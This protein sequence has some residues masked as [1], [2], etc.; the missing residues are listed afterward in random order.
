V[1]VVIECPAGSRVKSTYDPTL[2][3]FHLS[4]VLPKGS[5]FPFEFG[6]IPSTVAE[7]GDPLDM[8]VLI[9]VPTS[10]GCVLTARPIG[11]IE[12]NQ[13]QDGKTF[14][15][16][17]LIGVAMASRTHADIESLADINQSILD[18]IEQF[19]KSYN[20]MRGREFNPIRRAE[21]SVAVELVNRAI[22]RKQSQ[23]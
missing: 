19:F 12:A 4:Y 13:T 21:S 14:R 6:F 7:D 9:D 15:N 10:V 5:S 16:D 8:M 3:I 11:V 20:R 1:N 17:R 18:E 23:D 22:E 2:D